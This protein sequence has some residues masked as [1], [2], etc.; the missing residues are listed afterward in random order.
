MAPARIIEM[1]RGDKKARRGAVEYA[2][3]R[4]IGEMAGESSGW[5]VRVDEPLV[6]E[7]LA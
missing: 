7:A 2:L 5:S 1:T 6:R 4:R 3:P